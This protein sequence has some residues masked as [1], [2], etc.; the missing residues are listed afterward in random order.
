MTDRG[1]KGNHKREV[2]MVLGPLG[3][4]V[5]G[6]RVDSP[7]ESQQRSERGLAMGKRFQ[8]KTRGGGGR[9]HGR[10]WQQPNRWVGR[11]GKIRSRSARTG[12]KKKKKRSVGGLWGGWGGWGRQNLKRTNKRCPWQTAPSISNVG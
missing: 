12:Q 2:L 4:P 7:E 6:G 8:T 3:S 9:D 10:D 11:G 5:G 1:R